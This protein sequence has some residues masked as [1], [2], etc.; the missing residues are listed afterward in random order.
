[1][2]KVR[3]GVGDGKLLSQAVQEDS[4]FPNL[5]GEMI[6][7]GEEAG[8]LEVQLSKVSDFYDEEA[9]RAISQVTGMLTPAL[10]M[11]VGL[12]IGLIAVTIFSSIYSMV[13][14]LPE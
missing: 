13:D 5:M 12:I 7:V 6:R 8:S 3:A 11:G 4:V 10:T 2:A 9:E 14:V 1:V